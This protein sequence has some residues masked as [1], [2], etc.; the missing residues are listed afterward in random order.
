MA[1]IISLKDLT[2]Y[3]S[4][5]TAVMAVI[6]ISAFLS[7]I[8]IGL[9]PSIAYADT[10]TATVYRLYHEGT[11]EH[12]YTTDKNEY[13][14]LKTKGW[15]DEKIGWYAPTSGTPIYRLNNQGLQNH[16]YTS[17]Q[18]EIKTL[19]EKHGWT[20]DYDGKP[21]LYSG[22][23]EPIY[24]VY[25]KHLRGMHHL[26]TDKNEYDTLGTP[27]WGWSQEGVACYAISTAD[28]DPNGPSL[29]AASNDNVIEKVAAST[30]IEADVSLDGSGTGHHA[31]LVLSTGTAAISFGLQ[32]DQYA[33][34][35]YANKTMVMVENIGSNDP[36]NQQYSRP[37]N[38]AVDKNQAHKLLV[39]YKKDG[40]GEFF[41]DKI[42]IGTWKNE[43]LQNAERLYVQ[44]E[45]AARKNGDRVDANFSNIKI[46]SR[47]ALRDSWGLDI[48][49]KNKDSFSV[50]QLGQ[51][52]SGAPN[53]IKIAGTLSGI[54]YNSDWDSQDSYDKVSGVGQFQLGF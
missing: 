2:K 43:K 33:A 30:A 35:P 1:Q 45:G 16:L 8:I 26:T 4:S 18:N 22:G 46:K 54:P 31:K 40:T 27:K 47:D 53:N 34:G 10:S 5:L 12:L 48:L 9:V 11:L 52:A 51:N 50:S 6:V 20:M 29:P 39:T 21:M 32:F 38:I 24:R 28:G 19:T 23:Y 25:N 37:M 14:T 13:D 42:K 7:T 36:G 49:S 44:V 15:N 17:D 41:F 3:G